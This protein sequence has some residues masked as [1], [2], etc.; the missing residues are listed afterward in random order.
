MRKEILMSANKRA[1][2]D[3]VCIARHPALSERRE[4][5]SGTALVMLVEGETA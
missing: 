5:S 4:I 2:T 3:D 1:A